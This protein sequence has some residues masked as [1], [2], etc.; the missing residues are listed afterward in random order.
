MPESSTTGDDR[1]RGRKAEGG[2]GANPADQ[3]AAE[4]GAARKGDGARK[5]DPR[6]GGGQ[7]LRGDERGHQRGRG[8]AVD[9][10]AAHR[11]EAEQREQ[12][13]VERAE[14][15]QQQDRGERHRAQ[16]F[17]AGHQEA[18]RHAVGEQARRDREQD[19]GQ[20]ER[21]LQRAGLA[22]ADAEQQ[23]GDDGRRGQRD[24]LGRLR[25]EVG[26]GEAVEGRGQLIAGEVDMAQFRKF[27][28]GHLPP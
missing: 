26:P 20:R 22:F 6:I 27:G 7:L 18:A 1:E 24:L 11:G 15:D 8:D 3:H 16:R 10:G 21:R 12:G 13:Q 23:H 5:L 17:G 19:E 28:L 14:P 2:R 25:G 4:R 9:D